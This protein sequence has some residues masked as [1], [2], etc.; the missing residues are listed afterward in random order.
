MRSTGWQSRSDL[1]PAAA[2]QAVKAA[3]TPAAFYMK[4]QARRVAAL[5]QL[6]ERCL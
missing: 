5:F 6:T 2:E 4:Q 3:E 1:R